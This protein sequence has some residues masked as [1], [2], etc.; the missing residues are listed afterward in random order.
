MENFFPISSGKI[1]ENIIP[2]RKKQSI[3]KLL[4]DVS[5]VAR[6]NRVVQKVSQL[7]HQQQTDAYHPID[8][9]VNKLLKQE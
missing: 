2:S 1:N 8:K 9:G 3:C 7:T 5:Y 6:I 4:E